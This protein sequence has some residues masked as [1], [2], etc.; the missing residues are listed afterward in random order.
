VPWRLLVPC[1]SRVGSPKISISYPS[2]N[3]IRIH[4]ADACSRACKRPARH[5][6]TTT[7]KLV[8]DVRDLTCR[9]RLLLLRNEMPDIFFIHSEREREREREKLLSLSLS[10][11]L[12]RPGCSNIISP[13]AMLYLARLAGILITCNCWLRKAVRDKSAIISVSS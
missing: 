5:Y 6:T 12:F 4:R 8:V 11:S 13:H 1:A 10:L 7:I 3:N 9:A 2:A